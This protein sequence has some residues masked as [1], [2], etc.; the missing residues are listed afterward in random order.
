MSEWDGA[1]RLRER[2]RE[3]DVAADGV[4]VKRKNVRNGATERAR[5]GRLPLRFSSNHS[6]PY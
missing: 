5:R 1:R 3:A 2:E 6:I 4:E